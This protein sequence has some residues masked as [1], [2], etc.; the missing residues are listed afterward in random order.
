M[1]KEHETGEEQLTAL[2]ITELPEDYYKYDIQRGIEVKS[3]SGIA[4]KTEPGL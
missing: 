2:I 1:S 4:K 3:A